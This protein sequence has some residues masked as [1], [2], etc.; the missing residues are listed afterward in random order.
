MSAARQK[1]TPDTVYYHAGVLLLLEIGN[2]AG[3]QLKL[4]FV[5]DQGDEL[6]IRGFSLGIADGIAEKSLQSIQITAVPCHFDGVSDC[7]FNTGRRG[8]ECF[9]HLRIQYLGDGI[10]HVHIVDGND[11]GFPQVLVALDM[12]G[13]TNTVYCHVRGVNALMFIK[14][15]LL[16]H[17]TRKTQYRS[18]EREVRIPHR[19]SLSIEKQI[20]L[21]ENVVHLCVALCATFSVNDC[22]ERVSPL[23]IN[24][25]VFE[26]TR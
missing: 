6:T 16:Y 11:D 24:P 20:L 3:L 9:G 17:K 4:Q 10:D 21:P 5:S 7:S 1:N 14:L 22:L 8:L 25:Y 2:L 26:T 15:I 18:L 19:E 13:N 23:S 12:G